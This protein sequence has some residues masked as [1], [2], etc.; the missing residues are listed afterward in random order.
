MLRHWLLRACL[1][2]LLKLRRVSPARIVTQIPSTSHTVRLWPLQDHHLCSWQQSVAKRKW[3]A[4]SSVVLET[5]ELSPALVTSSVD[6]GWMS[7]IRTQMPA[8]FRRTACALA[9]RYIMRASRSIEYASFRTSCFTEASLFMP[10]T[11][12]PVLRTRA[13]PPAYC[14]T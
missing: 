1:F 2:V 6:W 8:L 3:S 13:P 4:I 10:L 7:I 14:R 11:V 12:R 9:R 5:A